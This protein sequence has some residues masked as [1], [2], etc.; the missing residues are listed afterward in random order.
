MT[1][2]QWPRPSTADR[3]RRSGG[4]RRGRGP[5]RR[6]PIRSGWRCDDQLIPPNT[7]LSPTGSCLPSTSSRARWPGGGNPYDNGQGGELHENLKVE[8]VYPMAY[9]TVDDVMADLP[10][11]IDLVYN[12][13]RLHSALGYRSPVHFENHDG[14]LLE[15]GLRVLSIRAAGLTSGASTSSAACATRTGQSRETSH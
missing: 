4:R 10:R 6:A 8:A 5:R 3:A 14:G 1:S 12:P 15:A 2:R 9:E 7:R 11:F 13:R